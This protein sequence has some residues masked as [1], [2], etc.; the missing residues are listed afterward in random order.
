MIYAGLLL[1][2]ILEY[3]RPTSY[4]P[5]LLPLHLNSIVP[6]GTAALT[7]AL[8]SNRLF[9]YVL[10][11]G[12]TLIIFTLLGLIGLSVLTADVTSYSW[13]GF[14]NV[15]GFVIAYLILVSELSTVKKIKGVMMMMILVHFIVAALNPVLFT[16]PEGR[17]FISS[18][19]FLGDGNDLALS[20]NIVIPFAFLLLLDS[21]KTL[22]KGLWLGALLVMI[23]AV[24]MTKS[25]G[26]TLALGTSAL[27][28]WWR[29]DKK[30]PMAAI[31]AVLFV[32]V[33]AMAPASY[34]ERMRSIGD[35]SESSAAGRINAWKAGI[36]MAVS[37]PILG[38]GAGHFGIKYA[39]EFHPADARAGEKTAHS[40]FFLAL[41]E[42][43]LPGISVVL[44]FF[45]YN[46]AA[47]RRLA[48]RIRAS[49]ADRAADLRLLDSMSV[50]VMAF[51]VGGA[52]LSCLYYPHLYI[53]GGITAATRQVLSQVPDTAPVATGAPERQT[54]TYHP[55][56]RPR[57]RPAA[58]HALHQRRLPQ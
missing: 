25:R 55:A 20:M 6:L 47:N 7:F 22:G 57:L 39:R 23:A 42:L 43:G 51:G 5:A 46:L 8:R 14:T 11:E 36:A 37:N 41:G 49:G 30:L 48:A 29:T 38:V 58:P 4:V 53:L 44:G 35:T 40:L 21:R 34:F 32:G 31:G 17:H 3:V 54:V 12:N 24:V 33:L 2:F 52:F 15:L 50:A 18:G 9:G 28:Y 19:S 13:L 26:G 10:Q 16:D 56:L 1:F 45:Y 27:F